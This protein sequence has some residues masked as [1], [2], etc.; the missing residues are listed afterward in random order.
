MFVAYM[1]AA[2]F[3]L[4]LPSGEKAPAGGTVVPFEMLPSNHMVVRVKL[5]DKG[6]FRLIFD[7]GAP[8]TV[9]SNQAAE[10]AQVVDEK[11]PRSFLFSMRG[12]ANIKKMQIGD[13]TAENMPAI[14]FDHPAVKMLGKAFGHP[15]DGIVGYTFFAHYKTTIDYQ[16]QRMAFEPVKF[17]VRNLMEDLPERLMGPRVAKHRTLS[18]AGLWG[19]KVSEPADSTASLG[20]SVET[21]LAG[22]PAEGAG[23]RQGD[24]ITSIDGRWTMLITDTYAAAATVPPGHAVPVG[25]VRGG[26]EITMMVTPAE[27]L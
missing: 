24:V 20:V 2:G 1:V 11:T 6:P 16:A 17:E 9:L 14:V 25:I 18:S 5:N 12:E 21:V 22:S 10:A 27:G 8:V 3:C 23:L 13:L 4:A 19:L 26:K 15:I 7:L